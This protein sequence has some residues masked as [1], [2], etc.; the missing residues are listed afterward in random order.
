VVAEIVQAD[1]PAC[2]PS[3]RRKIRM[4]EPSALLPVLGKY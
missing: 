4:R 1:A 2:R 3:A